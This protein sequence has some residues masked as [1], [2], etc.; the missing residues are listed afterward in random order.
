MFIRA[1]AGARIATAGFACLLAVGCQSGRVHKEGKSVAET[2]HEVAAA[3]ASKALVIAGATVHTSSG[4]PWPGNIVIVDGRIQKPGSRAPDSATRIELV[5]AHVYPGLHDAHAHLSGLGSKMEQVDLVGT[6]SFD[7]V[8]ARVRARAQI[9]PKGEWVFGRGWDQNDWPDPRMPVHDKLSAAT[10]DHPVYLT[11]V[12][13]HAA[14]VNGNAMDASGLDKNRSDPRGGE[15]LR[16]DDRSP[17]GVL[18]DRAMGF[19][20]RPGSSRAKVRRHLLKA[21]EAC[22]A[23]GLTCVHDAGMGPGTVRIVEQLHGEGKWHLRVY[24]MLPQSATAA[25]RKG[26]WETDD[27]R[28]MVRAV[29]GYADGALGSRGAALLAPYTDRRGSRGFMTTPKKRL[30]QIAQLCA[31]HGFQFCVH[32]IGDKAN[33]EVLDAFAAVNY[34]NGSKAA[35][36]RMEHAQVVHPDDFERFKTQGVIPSMQPTHLTSDMPWA[37]RRL[38]SDRVKGA[39]AWRSFLAR[40]LPL[41]F[42]SDFPV[43]T[44][45]EALAEF[46]AINEWGQ[47]ANLPRIPD[48]LIEGII[49]ER[50]LSLL[51]IDPEDD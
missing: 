45:A 8:I 3:G 15:I 47:G 27:K 49:N 5:G 33:R 25:I 41:A 12:D 10:P 35:R 46:R 36:F 18:V 51:G 17:T 1:T 26:P 28:I 13:G 20:R 29:K 14:L 38:G 50:P 44:T 7:E 2:G 4:K 9:T 6:G 30:Q 48:T 23:A 32:A 43:R 16:K 31:D 42:G 19:V 21:Q 34:P 24:A 22:L 39:Y 11:R 40:G 37:P